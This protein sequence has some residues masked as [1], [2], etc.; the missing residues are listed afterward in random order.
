M[1]RFTGACNDLPVF[2]RPDSV[3]AIDSLTN[4]GSEIRFMYGSVLCV[5]EPAVEVVKAVCADGD[6]SST[7]H[8]TGEGG[9]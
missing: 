4:G 7:P 6:W 2:V 5:R 9:E 8:P 3:V 1:L